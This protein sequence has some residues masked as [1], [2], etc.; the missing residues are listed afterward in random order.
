MPE[1]IWD[2]AHKMVTGTPVDLLGLTDC[3]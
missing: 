3:K 1:V 2:M